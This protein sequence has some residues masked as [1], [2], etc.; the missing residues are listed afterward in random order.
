MG[1]LVR[2]WVIGGLWFPQGLV[3]AFVWSLVCG[4]VWEGLRKKE[5]ICSQQRGMQVS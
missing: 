4:A 3:L 5:F 1:A 2:A